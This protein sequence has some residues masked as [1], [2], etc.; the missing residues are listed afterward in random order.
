M[1][2]FTVYYIFLI[3]SILYFCLFYIVLVL[4]F[5]LCNDALFGERFFDFTFDYVLICWLFP[6]R[7][8]GFFFVCVL[9]FLKWVRRALIFFVCL[10]S[11]VS[12]V[13]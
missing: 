7:I 4:C 9:W 13:C 3:C 6:I 8:C 12:V 5:F 10:L 1:F 2:A 11:V